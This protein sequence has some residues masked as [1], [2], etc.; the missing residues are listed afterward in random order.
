MKLPKSVIIKDTVKLFLNKYPYK[1]SLVCVG[2]S[3]FRNND[4]DFVKARLDL[5]KQGEPTPVWYKPKSP[6]DEEFCFKLYDQLITMKDYTIR[7][8]H[9]IINFYTASTDQ[10]E[11][12]SSID[13]SR[14]KYVSI[15]NKNNPSLA[16]NSVIVKKLDFDYKVFLGRTRQSHINFIEWAKNNKKIRLT[17]TA[18]KDLS[19]PRSWGGSYFYVKDDKTMTMVKM[20]LS[21]DIAKIEQVIKA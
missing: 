20:F 19:K 11:R 4:L 9:P 1:V 5:L 17:P 18:K 14:V 12:L 6:K 15:P 21:G 2:A 10:V 8:E 13:E 7:I 16:V 3:W